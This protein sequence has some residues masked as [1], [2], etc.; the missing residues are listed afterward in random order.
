MGAD[1][2]SLLLLL[3]E[4]FFPWLESFF[5]L[6]LSYLALGFSPGSP[7]RFPLELLQCL[8]KTIVY[9]DITAFGNEVDPNF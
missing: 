9:G 2:Q 7:Y 8:L 6:T 3:E 5:Y 4:R 1:S